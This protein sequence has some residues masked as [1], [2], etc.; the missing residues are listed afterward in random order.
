M[1]F[2]ALC[3]LMALAPLAAGPITSFI[4]AVVLAVKGRPDAAS[5]V[6]S[7]AASLVG[8][9]M[10]ALGGL[11]L[12]GGPVAILLS[13]SMVLVGNALCCEGAAR[14]GV[15][16]GH[17]GALYLFGALVVGGPAWAGVCVIAP[18]VEHAAVWFI[19]SLLTSATFVWGSCAGVL[20]AMW[21]TVRCERV[22][23]ALVTDW[24][25]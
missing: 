25:D 9:W 1:I 20:I 3:V 6:G 22:G 7:G 4:C 14:C 11:M 19:I 23:E 16:E 2:G 15:Y 24:S 13:A 8:A 17:P 5:M 12:G 21:A 10:I 18:V